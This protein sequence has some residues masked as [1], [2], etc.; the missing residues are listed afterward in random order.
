MEIFE[1]AVKILPT[2]FSDIFS[3]ARNLAKILSREQKATGKKGWL[4]DVNI[5]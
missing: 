5:S 4:M 1:A 3:P 2:F